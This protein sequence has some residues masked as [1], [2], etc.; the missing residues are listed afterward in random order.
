M[1]NVFDVLTIERYAVNGMHPTI[2]NKYNIWIWNLLC[3]QSDLQ[4]I[5]ILYTIIKNMQNDGLEF[6]LT[7]PQGWRGGDLPLEEENNPVKQYEFPKLI[8]VI[9]SDC[10]FLPS[11]ESLTCLSV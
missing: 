10:T 6:G 3:N 5:C 8:S 11:K 2:T 7:I 9:T 1:N 4:Q